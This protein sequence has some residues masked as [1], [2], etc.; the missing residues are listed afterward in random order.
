MLSSVTDGYKC[1]YRTIL[2]EDKIV[3]GN[4][5][6]EDHYLVSPSLN[7]IFLADEYIKGMNYYLL[8]SEEEISLYKMAKLTGDKVYVFKKLYLDDILDILSTEDWVLEYRESNNNM[9]VNSSVYC[10]SFIRSHFQRILYQQL[11]MDVP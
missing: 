10:N 11:Q 4:G 1:Y 6:K 3:I 5:K 7:S 2:D 8:Y 9:T